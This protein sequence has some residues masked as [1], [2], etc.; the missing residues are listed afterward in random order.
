MRESPRIPK[1]KPTNIWLNPTKSSLN[2]AAHINFP[3]DMDISNVKSC[4]I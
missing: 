3:D 1:E 2:T 4:F